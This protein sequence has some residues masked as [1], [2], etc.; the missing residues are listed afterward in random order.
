M[1]CLNVVGID[2]YEQLA[3]VT[4]LRAPQVQTMS[5]TTASRA[6]AF[7]TVLMSDRIQNSNLQF[8]IKEK[9]GK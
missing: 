4:S 6:P 3:I 7:L 1:P 8:A 9:D 2:W 5:Q